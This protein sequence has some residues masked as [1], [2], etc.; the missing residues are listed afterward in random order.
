M[1][2]IAWLIAFLQKNEMFKEAKKVDIRRPFLFLLFCDKN[3]LIAKV[4]C[5]AI[6]ISAIFYGQISSA[7]TADKIFSQL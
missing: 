3:T 6:N 1:R 2:F 7:L 5:F 4:F